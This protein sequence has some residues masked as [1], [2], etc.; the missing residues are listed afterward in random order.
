M[1]HYTINLPGNIQGDVRQGKVFKK[2]AAFAKQWPWLK[3]H[4]DER[5]GYVVTVGNNGLQYHLLKTNDG[6]WPSAAEDNTLLV[7]IKTA[8]K[9]QPINDDQVT[10]AIKKAIDD[11]ENKQ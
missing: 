10:L 6:Q 11:Y 5:T 9:W 4:T 7:A 3:L 8:D 1:A 2:R